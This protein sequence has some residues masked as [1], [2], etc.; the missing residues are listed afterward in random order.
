MAKKVFFILN[1]LQ[2]IKEGVSPQK[3]GGF[4]R[5]GGP[6]RPPFFWKGRVFYGKFGATQRG[7]PANKYVVS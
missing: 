3:G 1:A 4:L 2:Y 6:F 5:E 7:R